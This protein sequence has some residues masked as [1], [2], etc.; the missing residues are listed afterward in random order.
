MIEA[1]L[2]E[3][4]TGCNQCVSACPD[5]VLD[6]GP[7]NGIPIIARVDQ[8]Q[9]CFMCELYC[10]HDAIYVSVG[11]PETGKVTERPL[12]LI[13]RI[14]HDYGWDGRKEDALR[15][16]WQLGPL[17]REGLEIS[18]ARHAQRHVNEDVAGNALQSHDV[19]SPPA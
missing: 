11:D 8:C 14:R 17:L 18:A 15:D 2:P 5:H 7:A 4:C 1:I 12:D 13:G 9:T 10:P 6:H 19:E 3:N 16:F